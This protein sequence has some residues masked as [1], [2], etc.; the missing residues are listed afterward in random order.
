S[1][2]SMVRFRQRHANLPLILAL[3][4]TD[5]YCDIHLDESAQLSLDMADMFVL[6]QPEG[7]N[8]LPLSMHHKAEV[9]YQS[10]TPPPGQFQPKRGVFEI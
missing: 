5:L 10:V 7:I 4:G 6:L 9:I 8:Q 3:T 1:H 2:E